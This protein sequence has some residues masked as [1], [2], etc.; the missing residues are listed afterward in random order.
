MFSIIPLCDK[1]RT[2][3]LQSHRFDLIYQAHNFFSKAYYYGIALTR[4]RSG[5]VSMGFGKLLIETIF[6]YLV[7]MGMMLLIRRA[8]LA[9]IRGDFGLYMLT[10]VS[11]FLLHNKIFKAVSNTSPVASLPLLGISEGTTIVGTVFHEVYLQAIM[12]IM[13][14]A[15]IYLW[16]GRLDIDKP[17]MMLAIYLIVMI[18]SVAMGLVFYSL[19]PL[20]PKVFSA[21]AQVY[22]RIGIMTSG[23]MFVGN[24]IGIIGGGRFLF[25]I[26][27]INPLFHCID[28]M[29]GAVFENYTPIFT[30]IWYPLE[31]SGI[32]LVAGVIIYVG[33]RRFR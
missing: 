22:R 18:W 15:G 21:I 8:G 2:T 31:M 10:G 30:S 26:Y 12:V 27:L 9:P 3:L 11:C 33:T 13:F 14:L 1:R 32:F 5:S 28:Q 6:T 25:T 16:Y 24:V 20:A 29:R 19:T 17:V 23:K 4:K 7:T